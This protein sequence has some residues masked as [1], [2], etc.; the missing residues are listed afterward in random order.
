MK[1]VRAWSLVIGGAVLAGF[2]LQK[3]CVEPYRCVTRVNE[4]SSAMA[5]LDQLKDLRAKVARAET[6]LLALRALRAQCQTDVNI[7]FL[8][9]VN[10]GIA[11]RPE[12]AI[13]AYES[14]LELDHR[15]EIYN[16]LGNQLLIQGKV[17]QAVE[18]FAY[19]TRF[20]AAPDLT[21]SPSVGA[22]VEERLRGR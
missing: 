16:E 7:P 21:Y 14:A 5:G 20:G 19:S 3:F 15:P 12:A 4:V 17:D 18:A 22:L 11:G 6:N 9:G 10:E 8:I 13:A 2:A 1:I